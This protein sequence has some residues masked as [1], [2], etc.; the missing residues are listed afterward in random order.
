[1][2]GD[3]EADG[4][5]ISRQSTNETP[6]PTARR[7]PERANGKRRR[8]SSGETSTAMAGTGTTG[9]VV[10]ASGRVAPDDAISTMRHDAARTISRSN[11]YRRVILMCLTR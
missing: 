7:P 8:A 1:M 10:G 4:N 3:E 11:P 6:P 2:P 5:V 9:V